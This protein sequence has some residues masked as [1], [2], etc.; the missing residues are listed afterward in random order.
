MAIDIILL[1]FL[2]LIITSNGFFKLSKNF[3]SSMYFKYLRKFSCTTKSIPPEISTPRPSKS[4]ATKTQPS[5]LSE[6]SPT[7]L[8]L[9]FWT[10]FRWHFEINFILNLN[11]DACGNTI[12]HAGGWSLS[13]PF[14]F[15][16][17]T[18]FYNRYIEELP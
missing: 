10:N 2:K 6:K 18:Y 5:D 13:R 3:Y 16:S 4:V 14:I 1:M 11:F 7:A 12:D 15:N 8:F 17:I 9:A